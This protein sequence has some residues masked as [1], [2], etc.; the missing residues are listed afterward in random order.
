VAYRLLGIGEELINVQNGN[1]VFEVPLYSKQSESNN[2][3]E[4]DLIF[5]IF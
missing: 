4:K 5:L 3:C 1:N 2:L